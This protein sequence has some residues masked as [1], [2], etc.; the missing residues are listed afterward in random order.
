MIEP[1][2]AA[3]FRRWFHS[4][5]EDDGSSTVYRPEDFPF[6]RARGRAGLEFRPDGTLVDWQIGPGDA[7][8]PVEG[9]WL[10]EGPGRLRLVFPS[11]GP[12]RMVEL[13]AVED[14]VLRLRE[15]GPA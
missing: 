8:R 14:D 11:G 6:P 10:L 3:L 9:R 7:G 13:I 15:V 2:P 1:P 12:D 4:F 5:E